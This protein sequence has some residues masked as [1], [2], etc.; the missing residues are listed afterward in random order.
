MGRVSAR[1]LEVKFC[2]LL[3]GARAGKPVRPCV[4]ERRKSKER[5][6]EGRASIAGRATRRRQQRKNEMLPFFFF[7]R[8]Q[9]KG[10]FFFPLSLH[11]LTISERAQASSLSQ[12]GRKEDTLTKGSAETA[13]QQRGPSERASKK[14]SAELLLLRFRSRLR[15]I[16]RA[17]C[18]RAPACA[19]S[20]FL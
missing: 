4:D 7:L 15:K 14:K 8:L 1:V 5:N 20:P 9:S 16:R 12:K 10:R 17:P 6:D 13:P 3:A 11:D 2:M 18:V 19:S